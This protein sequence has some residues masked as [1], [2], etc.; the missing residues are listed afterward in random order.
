ML[1]VL[2]E[3]RNHGIETTVVTLLPDDDA[4]AGRL[5]ALEVECH[6]LGGKSW[7]DRV[8][9]LSR[10]IRTQN[11]DLVHTSLTW[12]DLIG[13]ACC[14]GVDVPVVTSLVNS[15]YGPAH[16]SH[17]QYG[18][19]AV[20]GWQ[21]I[22]TLMSRRTTLFHAVSH[23]VRRVM[24]RRLWIPAHRIRVVYRGRD[25]GRLGTWTP[26]RRSE[27]RR[28]LGIS[29]DAPVIAAVGRT[30][31]QKAVEVTIAAVAR[32]QQSYPGLHLLVIGRNGDAGADAR[33]AAS[34]LPNVCFLG[35]RSDVA[36]L[37]CAADCL[38]FPSRWEG[39]PGT[40]IEAL[41]LRLPV[42]AS[43]IEPVKEV[44]GG[45]PW[46]LV[47]VDNAEALADG[48]ASILEKRIPVSTLRDQ[49]RA[50]FADTFTVKRAATG[51]VDLYRQGMRMRAAST[52]WQAARS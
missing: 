26:T 35:H 41:A 29:E 36:D 39:L 7:P 15:S 49:G 21:G 45:V 12:S 47:G 10:L 33:R 40:V 4:L 6:G 3:L 9:T 28:A 48:L 32:L 37:M 30:D 34:N 20:R 44:L 43:D 50:R 46:P 5:S 52:R 19:W 8:T 42:V 11:P 14:A 2:P 13:R 1:E 25:E 27:A 31:H 38:S 18:S 23:E 51:M 16:R 17:S 24:A 22:D